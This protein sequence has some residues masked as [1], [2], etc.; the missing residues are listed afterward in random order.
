MAGQLE[1]SKRAAAAAAWLLVSI[2]AA[3]AQ[4]LTCETFR[5]RLDGALVTTAVAD[6]NTEA[7]VF[8]QRRVLPDGGSRATWKTSDLSGT[9]TCG[10]GDSFQEFYV[11]REV[12]P[13]SQL[14]QQ[15]DHLVALNGAAICTLLSGPPAAC[16][17]AGKLLLQNAIQQMGA[18]FA[19]HVNNPNGLS[20][21]N[22]QGGVTGELTAAPTLITF[23][24]AAKD[25]GTVD[26]SRPPLGQLIPDKPAP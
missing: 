26:A 19:K 4:P 9:L 18:G 21:A 2:G 3:A 15:V 20:H 16:I 7:P 17:D 22:F 1:V 23:S 24:L 14:A 11:S 10:G 12:V 13:K 5:S 25:G 8:E 6:A